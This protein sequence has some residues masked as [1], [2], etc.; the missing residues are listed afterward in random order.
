MNSRYV[1]S[2]TLSALALAAGPLLA[3]E[4][5]AQSSVKPDERRPAQMNPMN[6]DGQ[7]EAR[8][9]KASA[10]GEQPEVLTL[11]LVPT[12]ESSSPTY[13]KGCWVRF[14]DNPD[15][16]G[17]NVTLKGPVSVADAD[18]YQMVWHDWDSVIVGPKARVQI[19]DNDNFNDR[20]ATLMPGQRVAELDA[21]NLGLFGQ[22]NSLR[23][24]CV[25]T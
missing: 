12:A 2:A 11:V 6:K 15:F 17:R 18:D 13:A 9:G 22:V 3:A 23:V 19:Y 8:T 14:Y 21:G 7:K 25:G 10:G 24:S 20:T 5:G 4:H 16:G 1:A